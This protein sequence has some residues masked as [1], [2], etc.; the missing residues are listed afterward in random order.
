MRVTIAMCRDVD[1]VDDTICLIVR[2]MWSLTLLMNKA[3]RIEMAYLN[4]K[5]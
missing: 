1:T 5:L 4:Q 2:A 3:M